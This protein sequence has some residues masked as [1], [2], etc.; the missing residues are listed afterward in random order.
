MELSTI[1]VQRR[2]NRIARFV[3][4]C[5]IDEAFVAEREVH[6][7]VRIHPCAGFIAGA[8]RA[9]FT[10]NWDLNVERA[11]VD[12]ERIVKGFTLDLER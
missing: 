12:P 2:R 1:P 6:T 10:A 9:Y 5:R 8:Q 3:R 11:I 4:D 7:F